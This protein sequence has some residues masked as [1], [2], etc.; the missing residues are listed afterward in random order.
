MSPAFVAED[1]KEKEQALREQL[2]ASLE[3][4]KEE[5]VSSPD[6]K[7]CLLTARPLS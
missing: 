5:E 6:P 7:T 1:P 3:K 4:K 2:I